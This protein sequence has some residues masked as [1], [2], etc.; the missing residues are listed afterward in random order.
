MSQNKRKPIR[1]GAEAVFVSLLNATQLPQPD[2]KPFGIPKD[3]ELDETLS[4]RS[5]RGSAEVEFLGK[6]T[7]IVGSGIIAAGLLME[8]AGIDNLDAYTVMTGIGGIAVGGAV[9]AFEKL[10]DR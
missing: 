9:L 7:T 4:T 6:A 8:R 10:T 5:E 2:F 1:S 3:V